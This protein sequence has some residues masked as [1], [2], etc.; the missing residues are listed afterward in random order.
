MRSLIRRSLDA[1][2]PRARA[3][4]LHMGDYIVGMGRFR[5]SIV[6]IFGIVILSGISHC[7]YNF[8]SAESRVR[9][10]CEQIRPG[11][12][13]DQLREF[14]AAQGFFPE[15]KES[16]V[17]YVAETRTYGRFGCEVVAEAGYVRK[18]TYYFAD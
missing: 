11:M 13:V 4:H 2:K 8:V 17:S 10:V 1:I 18:A 6:T 12:A 5:K 16:G 9:A 14:V 7:T 3:G 15:P